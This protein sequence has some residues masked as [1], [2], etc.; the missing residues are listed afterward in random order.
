VPLVVGADG[1]TCDDPLLSRPMPIEF[2]SLRV[3][4]LAA[5]DVARVA[6]MLARSFEVDAGYRYL[7]PDPRTREAALA[8]FYT[9]NLAI[10][11]PHR[12]TSVAVHDTAGPVATV[13]VR[14]PGGVKISAWTMLKSGIVPMVL[15]NGAAFP[16]RM[17]WLKGT[18]DALEAEL[19]GPDHRYW[20]VHMMA[21]HEDHQGTGLGSRLLA[22]ALQP[23][24]KS[25]LPVVLTTHL[26]KNVLF[27]RRAGFDVTDER[28][29]DPPGGEPYTV[30]MMRRV[31]AG[32]P[33]ATSQL[34]A[35]S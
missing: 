22:R 9:R 11:L 23:C 20:H 16:R 31:G 2:D 27:Y 14:P 3:V 24:A 26:E 19:G 35:P 29:L 30:W 25:P 21:V 6:A 10:H 18:Y 34:R 15:A 5:A 8:D 1:A 12:C 17:L 28:V 4:T 32:Q 33:A 7:F 13:T